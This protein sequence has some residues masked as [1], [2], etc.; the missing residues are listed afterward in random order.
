MKTI[1]NPVTGKDYP[2]KETE[3]TKKRYKGLW[4]HE[5][6]P[7]MLRAKRCPVCGRFFSPYRCFMRL[8][9]DDHYHCPYH[10]EKNGYRIEIIDYDLKKGK[11]LVEVYKNGILIKTVW[12]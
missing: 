12:V 1:H 8:Y 4:K 3:K 2:V 5:Q 6:K 10:H 7:E 9:G 11:A